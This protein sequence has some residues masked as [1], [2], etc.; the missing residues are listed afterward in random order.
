MKSLYKYMLIGAALSL[1]ACND[2]F[3]DRT[4]TNNLT[5]DVFWRTTSDLESYCNGIYNQAASNG[6]YRFM[7]GFHSDAYSV[8]VT[9]PYS[10]EAM[11]DNFAT[12]DASQT[13][14]A[15]VAAGIENQPNGNPNYAS[16]DWQLLRRINIFLENYQK[17]QG[18][19]SEIQAYL[20][21][22]L[23]FRAWFY[24]Y[25]VQNYGDVPLI[26]KSLTEQDMDILMGE[27]TPRKEVMKQVLKDISDACTY[28]PAENG[29][30]TV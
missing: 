23:F 8:K 10:M 14:A 29:G 2:S 25:M 6:T 28:L 4:P 11:S 5:G 27:R 17:A 30:T 22:A 9:G 16:W 1:T 24:F 15:A 20:G 7:I 3:L 26:T 21:E 12:M 13:W 18:S 19:E